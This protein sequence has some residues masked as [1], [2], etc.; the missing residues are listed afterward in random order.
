MEAVGI[1]LFLPNPHGA[2]S[3]IGKAIAEMLVYGGARVMLTDVNVDAGE[4]VTEQLG[5][6]GGGV[7][8]R[9]VVDLPRL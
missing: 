1:R 6:L 5:E 4:S 3:G 9:L 7:V 2:A 8:W